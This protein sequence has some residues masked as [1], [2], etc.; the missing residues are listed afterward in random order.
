MAIWTFRYDE[1]GAALPSAKPLHLTSPIDAQSRWQDTRR[2]PSQEWCSY[3][4]VRGH[5]HQHVILKWGTEAH[6]RTRN[7]PHRTERSYPPPHRRHRA[8]SA[9]ALDNNRLTL[10]YTKIITLSLVRR[11]YSGTRQQI[12]LHNITHTHL[13]NSNNYCDPTSEYRNNNRYVIDE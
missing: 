9:R 7:A 11:Y 4:K 2:W 12:P 1:H 3:R 6:D 8:T 13:Y 5:H 10:Y